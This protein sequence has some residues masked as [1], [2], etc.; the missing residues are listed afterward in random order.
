MF[1]G[2]FK[3]LSSIPTSSPPQSPSLPCRNSSPSSV[4]DVLASRPVVGKKIKPRGTRDLKLLPSSLRPAVAARDRISHWVTPFSLSQLDSMRA[5]ISFDSIRKINIAAVSSLAE[6]TRTGYGSGL[7]RFTEFC[8]REGISEYSRMPASSTLLAAFVADQASKTSSSSINSWMSAVRAWHIIN[9]APWH[10]SSEFVAQVKL[11][12]SRMAPVSS[13]KSPRNPVTLEH[14]LALQKNL[15]P[16]DSFD[17]A[18]WAVACIAFWSCCRLGE[19]TVSSEKSFSPRLNVDRSSA[20]V[21]FSTS[22]P[23][24]SSSRSSPQE[25]LSFHIPWTK[26]T[27][28]A[29]A[30]IHVVGHDRCSPT[31]AMSNHL[32]VNASAPPSSHLFSYQTESGRWAPMVKSKFL[33]RCH[34]IWSSL[35][36]LRVHGHSFRIGGATEL[37]LGGMPPHVVASVGRWKSLA[38]LLYWRR[39]SDIISNSFSSSYDTSRLDSVN[40]SFEEFRL[41]SNIPASALIEV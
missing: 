2:K 1:L 26:V 30:D 39:V 38:F 25:S 16:S 34:S 28:D 31:R 18:V 19:L 7:L 24:S 33:D 35:G 21:T 29:G 41:R 4:D 6:T 12:A 32:K 14:I 13:K 9:N 17:A 22:L 8:D 10:G 40:K 37:L 27:K 23:T 11:G 15:N 36:L 5:K 3:H 20:A